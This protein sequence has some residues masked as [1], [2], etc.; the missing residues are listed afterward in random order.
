ML[1]T[2]ACVENIKVSEVKRLIDL[3]QIYLYISLVIF[4]RSK[5]H[6]FGRVCFHIKNNLIVCLF[7]FVDFDT[8]KP[9]FLNKDVMIKLII[10]LLEI[11]PTQ[12]K[13]IDRARGRYKFPETWSEFKRYIK[14]KINL[15]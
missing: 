2:D 12:S 11:V 13:N 7:C 1:I 14:F 3:S 9:L 4:I 5:I 8:C 6:D 10:H 15:R